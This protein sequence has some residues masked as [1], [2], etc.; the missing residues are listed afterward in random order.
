[1]VCAL[2]LAG[3]CSVAAEPL[4]SYLHVTPFAGYTLFP[5]H[6]RFTT[7]GET[8]DQFYVGGRIGYQV[9]PWIGFEL[10]GGYVPTFEV[11][12]TTLGGAATE[13]ELDFLHGSLDAMLTPFPMR[14]G[15]AFLLLGGGRM[16][17]NRSVPNTRVHQWNA[18]AGAG[19]QI[20]M[21]DAVG[22]RL[23]VR[24]LVFR[25]KE[26]FATAKDWLGT[27]VVGGGL[28]FA[29]GA[30]PR[31][32]DADGVPDRTDKCPGT[33]AG[34][35]VNTEGCPTDADQDKV[36]DGLDQCENTPVGAVVDARGCP[37]DGDGDGV[38]DGLDA[39]VGTPQGA[40]VDA[41]GC[42]KDA[43][44]DGVF[45]GLDKCE[46]TP[47]GATVDAG[48]CPSDADGDGV[49][50]GLDKCAGTSPGLRV[51]K[52]GC[53]IEVTERE[54]ELLDTG[55]IRLEDVRFETA[56]ATLDPAAFPSL[57]VVGEVLAKWPELRIEIGGHTDAR[58]SNAYNQKLS[59][60]RV[61]SV[62]DY[63]VGKFP[64]L[65]REQYTLV[66]Y[67][68]TKPLVPNNSPLNMAKNRRVEFKVLNRDVLRREIEHRKLLRNE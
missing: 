3:A 45:D 44:G 22:L 29:I 61:R 41:S 67:G 62:L 4:G 6:V 66:G 33:P 36:A 30:R 26:P 58:G 47:K 8:K 18:E 63:L 49:P 21:S 38:A 50:E 5:E 12:R 54:T 51:D 60:E 35:R 23:E 7:F 43:D 16:Q 34:A 56:K 31:D 24:E 64:Q 27:T 17:M 68:E 59:E 46:N 28:T 19:Y 48:G 9:K 2:A 57:D 53:P 1:M 52:D 10:A 20:W 15:G 65:K 39:C 13:P 14:H 25:S 40:T 11:R 42:P 55:M 32:T 37:V